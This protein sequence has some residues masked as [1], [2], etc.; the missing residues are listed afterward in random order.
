MAKEETP[1]QHYV[2][3]RSIVSIQHF[4][5]LNG[6]SFPE[7]EP[8]P[9]QKNP[10][11]LVIEQTQTHPIDPVAQPKR[12][13]FRTYLTEKISRCKQIFRAVFIDTPARNLDT[14]TSYLRPLEEN[15]YVQSEPHRSLSHGPRRF[16]RY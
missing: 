5:K 8:A 7:E 13:P 10:L 6:T 16:R 4:A 15:I 9:S 14:H 2:R 1:A 11:E 3:N 12:S